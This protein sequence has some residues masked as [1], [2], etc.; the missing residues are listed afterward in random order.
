MAETTSTSQATSRSSASLT[1]PTLERRAVHDDSDHTTLKALKDDSRH[2]KV[3]FGA[4]DP[5][6][7]KMRS[8][9]AMTEEQVVQFYNYYEVLQ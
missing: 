9:V 5:G 4:T 2:F 7:V 1:S 3:V 6:L 8:T